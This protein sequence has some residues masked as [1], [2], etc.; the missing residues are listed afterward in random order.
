MTL[1]ELFQLCWKAHWDIERFRESGHAR[2]VLGN[3][4]RH[5][6]PT[7]GDKN[8]REITSKDV[9]I[10][11][12]KMRHI[13]TTANRSMEI[14]SRI[15]N[16]AEDDEIL[17]PATNPCVRVKANTEK[18]RRRYASEKELILIGKKLRAAFPEYPREA[19][20][21]YAMAF[22]GARP[23]SL[24]R[25]R[26]DQLT[27]YEGYAVLQFY[28]KTTGDTGE[29]ETLIIPQAAMDLLDALETPGDLLI[30]KVHYLRFWDRLRRE[31]GCPDLWLRDFRRLYGVTGLSGGEGIDQ[32]GALLNHRSPHTTRR[33]VGLTH[34]KRALAA[35]KISARISDLMS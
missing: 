29:D 34:K 22:T 12:W 25:A 26:K 13:P 8:I 31:A 27:R 17:P 21:C 24:E 16:F 7:F 35:L 33:Y 20:F 14:L 10:W 5:I 11:H 2:E 15:F 23:R 1:S 32:I 4:R 3:W 28:G 6:E 30:G 19:A 18:V 9:R